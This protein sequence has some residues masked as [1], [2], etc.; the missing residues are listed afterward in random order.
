MTR[1]VGL[2]DSGLDDVHARRAVLTRRFAL[3]GDGRLRA[4]PARPDRHGH[5]TALAA[6]ISAHAPG[7]RFANAQVFDAR[8]AATAAGVAAALAW[9]RDAGVGLVNLSL[10]LAEDR[11]VLR[12][13]CR[14]ALAAGMLLV[15]AAPARGAPVY[16]AAYPGVLRV[17]GDARCAPGELSWLGNAQADCGACV[18]ADGA[19][20]QPGSPAGASVAAAHVTGLLT[21]GFDG[22][23]DGAAAWLR[24]QAR[25]HGAER[26]RA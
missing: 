4:G 10:G 5:G 12:E 11:T 3:D 9:L 23:A 6:V 19:P 15:A 25:W 20:P 24:G 22:P 26:R 16:P 8:A 14:D 17:C 7:V 18:T 1:L 13:A 21:A 2:V